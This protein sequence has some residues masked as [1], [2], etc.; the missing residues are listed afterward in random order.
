MHAGLVAVKPLISFIFLIVLHAKGWPVR[1][2][3]RK[4]QEN[5]L[6]RSIC[7]RKSFSR[8]KK[9]ISP[10]TWAALLCCAAAACRMLSR[11]WASPSTMVLVASPSLAVALVHSHTGVAGRQAQV[12]APGAH[13]SRSSK[14]QRPEDAMHHANP[15][16]GAVIVGPCPGLRALSAGDASMHDRSIYGHSP[17]QA[18]CSHYLYTT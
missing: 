3:Q 10:C 18:V 13:R 16:V 2:F 17:T 9:R 7:Y 8:K 14:Q 15:T 6:T 5:R 4:D 12:T 1:F 11:G